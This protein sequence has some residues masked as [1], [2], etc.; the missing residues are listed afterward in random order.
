MYIYIYIYCTYTTV[1]IYIYIYI[2]IYS[3]RL[4]AGPRADPEE[5]PRDSRLREV[6]REGLL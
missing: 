2:Y 4:R 5:V 6:P 3:K 1:Y